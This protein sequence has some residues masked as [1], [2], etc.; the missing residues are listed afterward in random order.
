VST[1][2]KWKE[3]NRSNLINRMCISKE[4]ANASNT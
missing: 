3:F 2:D 4:L 1:D